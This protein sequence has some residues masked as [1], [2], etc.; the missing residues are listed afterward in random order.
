VTDDVHLQDQTGFMTW[1]GDCLQL[2]F[3][4]DNEKT[5]VSTGNSLADA[6]SAHR[7]SQITLALTKSG[8]ECYRTDSYNGAM[9]K[10]G[11]LSRAELQLSVRRDDENKMTYY[12]AA[13]P[14]RTLGKID[15]PHVGERIGIALSVN[16]MDDPAQTDPKAV[17]L[18]GGVNGP[19][20][21]GDYGVMTL[22]ESK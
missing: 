6:A 21:I 4:I 3:D 11:P 15:S 13:I 8:P 19:K 17:G 5:V 2:A 9:L 14:W 10:V 12:E 16:D 7:T 22:G 20:A 1:R 18:F